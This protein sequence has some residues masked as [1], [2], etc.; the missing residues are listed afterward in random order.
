M[1]IVVD[2]NQPPSI[3]QKLQRLGCEVETADT[4]EMGG[5][6]ILDDGRVSI[7]RE[8]IREFFANVTH[9][10]APGDIPLNIY[11][12]LTKIKK[13]YETA[14]FLIEGERPVWDGEETLIVEKRRFPIHKHTVLG[15]LMG[16]MVW[17]IRN[18]VQIIH[19]T[20]MNETARMICALAKRLT[21]QNRRATPR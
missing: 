10:Y 20:N 14:I 9:Q 5:Q 18:K 21:K 13:N 6:Y 11:E 7:E 15:T 4:N 8:R 12:R 16:V 19:T 1:K 17:C 3:R 2:V